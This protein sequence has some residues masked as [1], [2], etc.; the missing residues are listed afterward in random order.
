MLT[1]AS[2]LQT[3]VALP[4]P[5]VVVC[6]VVPSGQLQTVTLTPLTVD[7]VQ[8]GAVV[9][10]PPEMCRISL[11]LSSRITDLPVNWKF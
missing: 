1:S 5:L 7:V 9:L 8:V 4:L 3:M 10:A 11:I 6:I 2:Y